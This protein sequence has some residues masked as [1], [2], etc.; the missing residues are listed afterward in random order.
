MGANND[1]IGRLKAKPLKSLIDINNR[2]ALTD[3]T[4]RTKLSNFAKWYN[5]WRRCAISFR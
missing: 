4:I 2:F 3:A 5:A 1:V